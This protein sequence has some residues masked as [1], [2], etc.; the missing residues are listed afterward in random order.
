MG[1]LNWAH[2]VT[3]VT[4]LMVTASHGVLDLVELLLGKFF[5]Y[6]DLRLFIRFRAHLVFVNPLLVFL[7]ESPVSLFLAY[8][9][10]VAL[11]TSVANRN[12]VLA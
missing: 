9:E 11:P 10:L 2:S 12:Q 6:S 3:G 1:K 7:S 4:P 5:P 8:T